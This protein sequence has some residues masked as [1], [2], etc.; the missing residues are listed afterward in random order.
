MMELID[1]DAPTMT[2]S[3]NQDYQRSKP[4]SHAGQKRVLTGL[5]K[6]IEVKQNN[7]QSIISND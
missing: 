1:Q 7:Y 3:L 4:K 5:F 6:Q 2:T